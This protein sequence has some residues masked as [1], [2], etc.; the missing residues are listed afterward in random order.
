VAYEV[1]QAL[2]APLDVLVVRKL[3]CPW[4]P[5]LGV[6]ALGEGGIRLLNESLLRSTGITRAELDAVAGREDA[7]L[8]R[9][10]RRYRGEREPIPVAG[11][12]VVVVDDGLATGFTARAGS[13]SCAVAVPDGSCSR[14][15]W[16]PPTPSPSCGR[17]RTRWC[18]STPLG[19]PGDRP[20]LRR[21]RSDL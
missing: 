5:E 13:R 11:R 12:T 14:S 16:H 2:D 10:V 20:V 3:G 8:Q 15:R 9:R 18:A 17:S 1:A 21:L 19:V 6:G 4:Q 7:E